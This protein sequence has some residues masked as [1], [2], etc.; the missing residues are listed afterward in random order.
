MALSPDAENAIDFLC[1]KAFD[2]YDFG[3]SLVDKVKPASR[4]TRL[5]TPAEAIQLRL[6]RGNTTRV[7][8]P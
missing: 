7:T 5:D 6:S 8:R 4:P 2:L 1:D 3:K